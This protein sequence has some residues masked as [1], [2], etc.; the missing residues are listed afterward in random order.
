L[1]GVWEPA[2]DIEPVEAVEDVF[3]EAVEDG[4]ADGVDVAGDI[5]ELVLAVLGSVIELLL[6]GLRLQ[7]ASEPATTTAETRA[8]A[9][10]V[11]AFM[12]HSPM[13][14]DGKDASDRL[15]AVDGASV[16]A[17]SAGR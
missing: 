1:S 11:M 15:V 4:G 2:D 6:S 10:W 9:D 17:G 12:L 7:A 8:S 14:C 13:G 3:E 16:R 5:V